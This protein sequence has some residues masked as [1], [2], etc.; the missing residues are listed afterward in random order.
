MFLA[1]SQIHITI[2]SGRI[3]C[4]VEENFSDL[5]TDFEVKKQVR[6]LKQRT[7][8]GFGKICDKVLGLCDKLSIR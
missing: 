5:R 2:E 7:G 4:R 3:M 6:N 8:E 1:I